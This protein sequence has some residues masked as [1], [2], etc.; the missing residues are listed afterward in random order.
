MSTTTKNLT[1][2]D[3]NPSRKRARSQINN[4]LA[5]LNETEPPAK[6][7]RLNLAEINAKKSTLQLSSCIY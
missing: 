6:K 5:V 1:A 4:K 3:S 2:T 7:V